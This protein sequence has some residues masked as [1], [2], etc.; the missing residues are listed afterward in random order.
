MVFLVHKK[1][2]GCQNSNK[3]NENNINESNINI[4]RL[5]KR[6]NIKS[7]NKNYANFTLCTKSN[8]NDETL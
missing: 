1:F 7:R 4:S 8:L 2:L 5:V 6:K 3:K